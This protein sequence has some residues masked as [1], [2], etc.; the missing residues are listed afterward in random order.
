HSSVERMIAPDATATLAFMLDRATGLVDGLVVY[1]ENLRRNLDRAGEL[2]FGEAT[3]LALVE[4]GLPRQEAY[5]LVQRNAMRAWRGEGTF[6][7]LLAADADV[8]A[9]LDAGK[10]AALFD[11]DHAL[12]HVPA[13]LERALGPRPG[14][15]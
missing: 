12:A 15:T 13:I 3:L 11:L 4:A 7:D 10:L 6:R 2:Y 9:K 14:A 8:T 5:G 1:T